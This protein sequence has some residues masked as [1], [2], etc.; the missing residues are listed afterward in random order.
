[1]QECTVSMPDCQTAGNKCAD[2]ASRR[3]CSGV[4][5]VGHHLVNPVEVQRQFGV[6]AGGVRHRTA[7]PPGHNACLVPLIR[8]VGFS[9]HERP[10]TVTLGMRT[11]L[12]SKAANHI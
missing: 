8:C 3:G 6:D 9:A 7:N 5:V 1:M 12:T 10:A 11:D 2:G 4:R